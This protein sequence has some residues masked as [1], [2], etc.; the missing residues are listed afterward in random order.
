MRVI[1][2]VVAALLTLST[3]F[4]GGCDSASLEDLAKPSV[5]S[6]PILPQQIDQEFDNLLRPFYDFVENA[7]PDS[8]MAPEYGPKLKTQLQEL[9]KKYGS[10]EH[11]KEAL[12]RVQYKLEDLLIVGRDLPNAP[13]VSFLC[14]LLET[15][16]PDN[17]RLDRFRMWATVLQNRPIVLVRGWYEPLDVELPVVYV[18]VKVYVPG[19][20]EVVSK[21]IRE[22][23]E[24]LGLKFLKILGKKKGIRLEYK[25]TGDV[26]E[27]YGP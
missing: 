16:D 5:E 21:R 14:E 24:F 1:G 9:S 6:K 12:R 19:S 7:K 18:F 4:F 22:G 26:F 25:A 11:G 23:E 20:E 8:V 2:P 27:V 13:L 15:V 17:S 3:L 10:V